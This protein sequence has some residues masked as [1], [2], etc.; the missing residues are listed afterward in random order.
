LSFSIIARAAAIDE[1]AMALALH[2]GYI[3]SVGLD[4]YENQPAIDPNLLT[5]D[6]AF[7]VPHIGT[8][9]IE[10]LAMIETCA[11]DNVRRGLCGEKLLTTIPEHSHLKYPCESR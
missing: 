6:R 11:M 4:V 5:C 3:A 8:H 7:L 1:A 9:T 2:Q 10:T